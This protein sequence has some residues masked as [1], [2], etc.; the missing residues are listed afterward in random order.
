[1]KFHNISSE[2]TLIPLDQKIPGFT[3]FIGAWLYKGKQTLLVDPGP[4]ATVN[5]L[6]QALENL[7][8]NRLDAVLLTHIHID[9]AGGTGD[10]IKKFPGTPVVCHGKAIQ[11]LADP[12][13]L[14]EGSLKTL[15]DTAVAYGPICPVP[16]SLLTD[17]KTFSDFNV[18]PIATPGHAVHHV[19]YVV[20]TCLF[21]G[22]TGG[23]RIELPG[24]KTWLRPATPPR[25]IM[26]TSLDSIDTLLDT[27]HEIFCYGHFGA[28]KKNTGQL[29]KAHKNQ[30]FLWADVIKGVMAESEKNLI[31]RCMKKL[32]EK[33]P[34]L[35]PYN[36]LS[37]KVRQREKGFMENSVRGFAGYLRD[38]EKNS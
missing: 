33:D 17:S 14:W 32:F 20:D 13:R 29:L 35:L 7:G 15:G 30:I 31:Y 10:L 19:S 16:E 26:E 27:P 11:H 3:C 25:F 21:A 5:M 24:K 1:M 8:I 6:C 28:A 12:V 38:K 2:L 36:D 22:E 23:V 9:H 18:V 37:D 34:C 4:T